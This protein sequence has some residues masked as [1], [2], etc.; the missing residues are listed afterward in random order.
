MF[1]D[2]RLASRL[3]KKTRHL[4]LV[5][6]AA[7]LV[8]CGGGGTTQGCSNLDPTRS[9]DL[10]SCSAAASGATL[11]VPLS[12]VVIHTDAP[13][14]FPAALTIGDCTT[15]I[16]FVFAGGTA[17]FTLFTSDNISIPVSAALPIGSNSYFTASIRALGGQI[18]PI[19]ATLTVIDSQ[20]RTATANITIPVVHASCP[21]NPLLQ[22]SPASA[23]MR[24]SEILAFQVSGG[25]P[26]A[27]APF[28][29]FTFSD[30]AIAKVVM[31]GDATFHVQAL[32]PGST[33]LT[34]TSADGQNANISLTVL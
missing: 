16:P 27:L 17:P 9:S 32:T 24:T 25:V 29:S 23:A 12:T 19:V 6:L 8:A 15:N 5:A 10:P 1:H 22:T 21:A 2:T 34:V 28:H 26:L 13:S 7:L 30:P 31:D 14:I 33:L 20:S 3:T 18:V 11:S 4:V